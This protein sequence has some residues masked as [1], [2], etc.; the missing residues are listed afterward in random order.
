MDAPVV[1]MVA[2]PNGAGKSSIAPGL[3][4]DALGVTEYVN[5]DVIA[6]GIS[7]FNPDGAAVGAGRIMLARLD[8][9]AD[10]RQSFAFETTGASR[11]FASRLRMLRRGGYFFI[12]VYVWVD[13]ADIAVER[14]AKRVTLGGHSVPEDT[15][16]RRYMRGLGNFFDLYQPLADEWQFYDNSTPGN[17]ILIAEGGL[18]RALIIH[19][20]DIW[21][22]VL[23]TAETARMET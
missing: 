8:E 3:L 23:R 13:S 19:G 16:R 9:L 17:G 22:T 14:V 6:R 20:T 2:G 7:G 1:I 15:I 11:S 18:N 4:A 12:L 10:E 21:R 5:A